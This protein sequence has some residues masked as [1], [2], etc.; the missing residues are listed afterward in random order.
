MNS[1]GHPVDRH[2]PTPPDVRACA[3]ALTFATWMAPDLV[4][5]GHRVPLV[6]GRTLFD[7]A[8]ELELVVPA[9]CRRSGRCHEC[10]VEVI[11]GGEAL[12]PPSAEEAFLRSGHRLA[13]RAA[14]ERTDTEIEFVVLRRRLRIFMPPDG[15]PLEVDPAVS[16]ID[17]RVR[18]L[19]DDGTP[20]DDLGPARGRPLGLA[21][22]VGTTTVVLELVDLAWGEALAAAAF[23][24]PQRFGGS[25]GNHPWARGTRQG[26]GSMTDGARGTFLVVG[27]N[28]HATRVLLRNGAQGASMP[29]GR[30]ALPFEDADGATRL[31]PVPDATIEGTAEKGKLRHV[32][33]AVLA[34]LAGGPDAELG[35]GYVRALA[36]RQADAGS[37]WLDLNVDEVSTDLDERVAAVRWLVAAVQDATA[38]PISLDS[39][40]AEVTRAGLAAMTRAAGTPLLNSASLDR[41][42]VLDLAA[43]EGCA[44]MLSVSSGGGM[45]ANAAERVANARRIVEAAMAR[46]FPTGALHVDALV[47][48]V[49]VAPDAGQDFLD[50]ARTLRAEFGSAIHLNRRRVQRQLRAAG[51]PAAQRRH[52]RSRRPGRRRRGDH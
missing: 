25:D 52:D 18:L 40:S 31:L 46:G 14:V 13:Y 15:P 26:E 48:P 22:D 29:D 23:E 39:S 45:P 42:E 20:L 47:L 37:D 44:V 2:P 1:V 17:G 33:A 4:H 5:A 9:S 36:R 6:P 51:A 10:I 35:R 49:V 41:L 27:E 11:A 19:A 30:P 16:V 24:N 7:P 34:G 50:A 43:A 8:D 21:L 28:L 32:K 3:A 12:T 38:V